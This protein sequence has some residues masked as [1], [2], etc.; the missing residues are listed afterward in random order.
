MMLKEQ[1]IE[2][3]T[4]EWASPM[5]IIKKKDST[6][7]LR[8]DYWKLNAETYLRRCISYAPYWW[9]PGWCGPNKVYFYIRSSQEILAGPCCQRRSTQDGIHLPW[10]AL[11]LALPA[12]FQRMMDQIIRGQVCQCLLTWSY[13]FQYH[14]GGTSNTLKRSV[15]EVRR[16]RFD[17]E[18][19][20]MPAGHVQMYILGP[21]SGEW[22]GETLAS[23]LQTL[24][25][26]PMPTTKK[27]VCSFHG[28]TGNY[29][30]FIL[31]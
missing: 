26:F 28:L 24:D 5:V 15:E 11:C 19:I 13:C 12:T 21:C 27:Q 2:R 25:Q 20:K 16:S 4:S 30:C 22:S 23:K 29:R 18:T 14:L 1:I 17:S 7:Q 9:H 3:S 6:I 10:W 8:V 31:H